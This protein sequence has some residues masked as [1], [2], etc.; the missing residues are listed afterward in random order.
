MEIAEKLK[1]VINFG[2]CAYLFSVSVG[3]KQPFFPYL[4]PLGGVVQKVICYCESF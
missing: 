3:M 1:V 4:F 2:E